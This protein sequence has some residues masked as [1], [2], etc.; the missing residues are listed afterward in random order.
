[1]IKAAV[2][3]GKVKKKLNEKIKYMVKTKNKN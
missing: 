3:I 2:K 1:M